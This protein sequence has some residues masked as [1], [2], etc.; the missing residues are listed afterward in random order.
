MESVSVI[1]SADGIWMNEA[2]PSMFQLIEAVIGD[3]SHGLQALWLK[4]TVPVQYN[5]SLLYKVRN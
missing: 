1:C 2:Y 3:K 5:F 4:E